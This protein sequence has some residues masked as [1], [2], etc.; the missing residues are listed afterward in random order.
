MHRR[1]FVRSSLAAAAFGAAAHLGS[2]LSFAKGK[3]VAHDPL[4]SP[5][6]GKYGGYP[7][8]D[9]IKA[10]D[11]EAALQKAMQLHLDEVAAITATKHAATFENTILALEDAGRAYNRAGVVFGIHVSVLNDKP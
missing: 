1:T 6:T 3:P 8:F 9:Q 7:P 4:L 10:E 5:W 11:L 2:R